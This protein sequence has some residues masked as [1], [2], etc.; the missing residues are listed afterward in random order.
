MQMFPFLMN[1]CATKAQFT[2]R[3][4][5]AHDFTRKIYFFLPLQHIIEQKVFKTDTLY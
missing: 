2:L 5:D 4:S 3:I 1:T